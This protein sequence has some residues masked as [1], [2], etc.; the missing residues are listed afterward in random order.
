MTEITNRRILLIDDVASIHE[1]FR[2]ILGARPTQN[3]DRVEAALFDQPVAARKQGF[4]LD[5]AH[6]GREGLAMVEAAL[7]AGSPYA[8]AFVD[9]R[10]PPGWDGVET[11]ERLWAV[12]PQLQIVIC[13]AFSDHPWEEVMNRLDVRDRLLVL[14]KPFDMVEVSQLA[15]TLTAKW[16]MAR[17][18][19]AQM[20]ELEARVLER[21]SE[22]AIARDAAEAASRAKSDF[23]ANI[24]HELRTPMNGILGLLHLALK[25]DLTA[26]QRD[27]LDKAQGSS[28]QLL[29]IITDVLDF[30][31]MQA[32]R[33]RL[34]HSDFSLDTLL[35]DVAALLIDKSSAKGL[36]LSFD[37]DPAVPMR[38]RGDAARLRQILVCF[39]DNAVKFTD[40][41][42]VLVG[43]RVEQQTGDDVLLRFE[44][45]DT[46]IGI[47]PAQVGMLFR[48]FEQA[49]SSSTRKFGGTGLG[50]AIAKTL[51]E[52][53]GGEVGLQSEPG[54]GS[55]FW[56][57]ARLRRAV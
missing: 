10:M 33:L 49:D 20:D 5:S 7:Q 55:T 32:G 57:T 6:Q 40:S 38:L 53:M 27:Y 21:T 19:A 54:A 42:E 56:F 30:S 3:L 39:A 14:K 26:R 9:M 17:Q 12:D 4:E 16:S 43:A 18:A 28:K 52:L 51:A 23:L 22:L 45:R 34:E 11:V 2:K 25:T 46:G 48:G 35:E 36:G 24:S 13:T 29:R 37:I 31:R 1:D 44:V 15:R 8:M 50:L 47:D 41:G